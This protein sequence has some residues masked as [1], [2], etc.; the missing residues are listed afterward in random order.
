MFLVVMECATYSSTISSL[1]IFNF[2]LVIKISILF[3][4][5]YVYKVLIMKFIQ[6]FQQN[7]YYLENKKEIENYEGQYCLL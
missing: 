2:H 4:E 6:K 7:E 3:V 5:I 1:I